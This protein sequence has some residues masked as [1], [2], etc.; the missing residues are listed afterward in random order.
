M[1]MSLRESQNPVLPVFVLVPDVVPPSTRLMCW[2]GTPAASRSE[3]ALSAAPR[4][5]K[6]AVSVRLWTSFVEKSVMLCPFAGTV[7]SP[8]LALPARTVWE[9]TTA[10]PTLR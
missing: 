2:R 7:G 9:G 6:K 3:I 8:F 4:V 1:N 10:P 5:S